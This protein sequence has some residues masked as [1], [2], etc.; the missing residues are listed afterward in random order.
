MRYLDEKIVK[1]NPE[2]LENNTQPEP[3][4]NLPQEEDP[5]INAGTENPQAEEPAPTPAENQPS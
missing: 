1:F 2:L 5:N 4:A 3:E